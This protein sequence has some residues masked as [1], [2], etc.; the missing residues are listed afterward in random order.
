MYNLEE[1]GDRLEQAAI[2]FIRTYIP[3]Y[4]RV[5]ASYIGNKGDDIMADLPDLNTGE[6]ENRLAFSEFSYTILESVYSIK[7]MVD[8]NK[9]GPLRSFEI[10][11]VQ[12][13]KDNLILLFAHLG[14]IYDN[15][16][17][18]GTLLGI[19]EENVPED[20][21]VFYFQRH[22]IIHGHV[23]PIKIDDDGTVRIPKLRR[24]DTDRSGYYHKDN[25]WSDIER[26]EK[27]VSLDVVNRIYYSLLSSINAAYGHYSTQIKKLLNG[28]EIKFFRLPVTTYGV[29]ASGTSFGSGSFDSCT[30][31]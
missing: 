11:V 1:H 3:N 29:T 6:Q 17:N 15:V 23:L 20:L 4:Q 5:W 27:E 16:V 25:H 28:R 14:R 21:A 8:K 18:A 31:R 7:R 2:D 9:F 30:T 22:T 24:V 19:M 26:L 12:D 13:F 10:E